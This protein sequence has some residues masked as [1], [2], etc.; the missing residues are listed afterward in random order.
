MNKSEFPK[1]LN[2][3]IIFE[4]EIGNNYALAKLMKDGVVIAT[5]HFRYFD[6]GDMK[7]LNK[8]KEQ[9]KNQKLSL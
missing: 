3:E 5:R 8:L 7:I 2:E 4:E 1:V 9:D 6:E